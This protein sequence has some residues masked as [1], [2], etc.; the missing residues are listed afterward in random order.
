MS[1]VFTAAKKIANVNN[2]VKF[3]LKIEDSLTGAIAY[4]NN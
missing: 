2:N 1:D 4:C 3:E